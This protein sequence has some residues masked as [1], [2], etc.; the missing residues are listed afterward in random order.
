MNTECADRPNT[1]ESD[2]WRE[3]D[4]RTS[5]GLQ[6]SLLWCIGTDEVRI[7]VVDARTAESFDLDVPPADALAAFHHPFSYAPIRRAVEPIGA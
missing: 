7:V 3:L 5:D 4:S 2:T 1:A 6:I